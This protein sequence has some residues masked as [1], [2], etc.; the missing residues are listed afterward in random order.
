[1]QLADAS[2][3]PRP[4]TLRFFGHDVKDG[5]KRERDGREK[6]ESIYPSF[7]LDPNY[8]MKDRCPRYLPQIRGGYTS[9]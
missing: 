6:R 1:M 8:R 7:S 5:S 2:E 4:R 3:L 9:V